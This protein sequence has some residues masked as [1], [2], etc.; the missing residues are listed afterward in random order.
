MIVTLPSSNT[1]E[2]LDIIP[3]LDSVV[4]STPV[5]KFAKQHIQ[6]NVQIRWYN[7]KHTVSKKNQIQAK[8]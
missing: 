3:I 7:G 8:L 2:F 4:R 6:K 1:S 5:Y